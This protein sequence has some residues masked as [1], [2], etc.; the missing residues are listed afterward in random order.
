ME[1]TPQAVW[2]ENGTPREVER[3]VRQT[4]VAAAFGHHVPILTSYYVPFR[5]CAQYSAG[6]AT[7]AAAY[8]AWIEGFAR[9]IGRGKAVVILEPDSLGIIP[10]NKSIFGSE[11]WCKPTVAD[12]DGNPVPA[13]G[14]SPEERYALIN[15]A[16]DTLASKA[17]NALVYLDATH[18]S[19]LGVGEAAY[20]LVKAGVRRARGFFLNVS[21]YQLTSDAIQFGTWVSDVIAAAAAGPSWAYDADGNFHYDW[22]PSQYDPATNYTTV[23]YSA[24]YAAGVTSTFQVFM[25]GAAATTSFVIDTSR[26][27]QGPLKTAPY[28]AAPYNQPDSVIS[29]L[30]GGNWC[31]P[32]GAGLGLRPTANTGVPLLDAY[33]W[34]KTP[35][36]SD[37]SCDIAGG[38]RAWDYSQYNPWAVTGDDQNHFDPLWGM[39]DPGG[40]VWFPEQ[41][42][43]LTELANPP[44][45][46]PRS[47]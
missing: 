36:E 22:L 41:A 35:G 9:G 25:N 1:G 2:F 18:S 19:W 17:P 26:N 14:A 32:P 12:A 31:N 40:G 33:L 38:A 15:Y 34:V 24:D 7:D 21:N 29:G 6:G 30:N 44:L 37:G 5:D 20:R 45:L 10:F 42:L 28:A 27:G 4:M 23:N 11:E 3:A 13:P 39:T 47:R 16:V 8:R 46:R 43:E